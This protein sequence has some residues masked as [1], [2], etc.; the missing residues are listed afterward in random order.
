M[1]APLGRVELSNC[2]REF[3]V[4]VE[5]ELRDSKIDLAVKTAATVEAQI[6]ANQL[7]QVMLNLVRNAQEAF[8]GQDGKIML[9]LSCEQTLLHGKESQVAAL[10]VTHN[11]PG[12]SLK[13]QVR[14]FDPFSPRNPQ[15]QVW[16]CRSW[17]DWSKIKEVKSDSRAH[18]E[19][20]LVLLCACPSRAISDRLTAYEHPAPD[21]PD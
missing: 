8:E 11:G 4:L 20:A 5:P 18:R 21:V 17:R 2:L 10:S 16:A 13:V 12:I 7:R 3:A 6:D 19:P 1:E 14:L 9:T 15:G